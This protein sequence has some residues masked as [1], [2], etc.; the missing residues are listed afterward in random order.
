MS[1]T[2]GFKEYRA[3][4][5]TYN[6][7][8]DVTLQDELGILRMEIDP[9]LGLYVYR[10]VKLHASSAAGANGTP[11]G[12]S[13]VYH[14]TVTTDFQAGISN[15]NLPAGVCVGTLTAGNIGY[16]QCGGY[17]AAV[18]SNGD[19]DVAR[20]DNVILA[21]VDGQVDSV[22]AGTAST[23]KVLGICVTDDAAS[24]VP[25]QLCCSWLA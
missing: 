4:S 2:L 7:A 11:V 21:G 3:K 22:A 18:I 23:Y 1:A 15:R 19:N 13:D 20:G 14:T 10:Q 17:H 25:T 6:A 8:S 9:T 24:A 12:F 5:L 16:V